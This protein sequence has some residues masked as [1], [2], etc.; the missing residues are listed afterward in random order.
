MNA[1][2]ENIPDSEADQNIGWDLPDSERLPA[3]ICV[4][5]HEW[6]YI[7][8]SI[9]SLLCLKVIVFLLTLNTSTISQW[10]I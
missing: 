2:A 10:G 8:A 3:D 5:A 9:R 1:A 6:R 4:D 7:V